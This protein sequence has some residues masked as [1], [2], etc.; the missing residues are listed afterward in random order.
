MASLH[1]KIATD[2]KVEAFWRWFQS[3][4]AELASNFENPELLAQLDRRVSQ[5]GDLAWELGP[6]QH[7]ANALVITPDGA[8]EW[9][10]ATQHIVALAPVIAGWEFHWARPP[11]AWDLQF[12]IESGSGETIEVDARDWRYVL[13]RFPDETFDIVLEQGNLTAAGEDDRYTAAVVLLDGVLGESNRLKHIDG[14][15]AV[16]KLSDEHAAHASRVDTLSEHLNSLLSGGIE[17]GDR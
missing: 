3:I 1:Q 6:G 2:T 10:G 13:F 5:L 9:L 4:A 8:P 16:L 15:E 14:I 12:S 11:R 17:I 7:E